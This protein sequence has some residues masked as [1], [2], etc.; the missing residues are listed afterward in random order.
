MLS[1]LCAAFRQ[2][3]I[4]YYSAATGAINSHPPYKTLALE[5]PRAHV[6]HVRLNRPDKRNS[7]TVQ[8]FQE[9][10]ECFDRIDECCH[11]RA[12][13]LS[14][15]G[16]VFS[17]G[18]DFNEMYTL[19]SAGGWVMSGGQ[20]SRAPVD[21]AHNAK[22]I[23][24]LAKLWQNSLN[25][26]AE[27]SKPVVAAVNGPCLGVG[28]EMAIAC[29]V[30][31]CSGDA[32]FSIREVTV[33]VA[34]DLGSI[35]RVPKIMGN[36]SLVRELAFTGR[37]LSA[38][39]ALTH[40]LVSKVLPTG[41]ETVGSA[42]ELAKVIAGNSPVAVQGSKAGLDYSR[43]HTVREGLEFMVVWNQ[44]MIQSQDL[45]K[46]AMATAT[47]ATKPPVFDDL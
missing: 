25:S 4:R 33:G 6:L 29:D 18:L 41:A 35:Q 22:V 12:V 14:G 45:L 47:R 44:C 36:D 5:A 1:T 40:G 11:T 34:T 9:L 3:S 2:H 46:A 23:R 10:R 43:N 27:C 17:S 39:D 15:E 37:N 32:Y 13:V 19:I 21:I 26:I 20:V 38:T 31:H 28:L 8:V 16:M 42:I 30:R 24:K 7:I